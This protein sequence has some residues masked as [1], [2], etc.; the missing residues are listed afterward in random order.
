METHSSVLA[1]GIP[2]MGEPGG[3]PSVGSHRVRHDWSDLVEVVVNT[4]SAHFRD[5]L[6][7]VCL[8]H[9]T[10][11]FMRAGI[12][13]HYVAGTSH[14][15]WHIA[16]LSN[17]LLKGWKKWVNSYWPSGHFGSSAKQRDPAGW[18]YPDGQ[19][20]LFLPV[21]PSCKDPPVSGDRYFVVS[22][23]SN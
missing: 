9:D 16:S 23:G 5:Y 18:L 21:P 3:L 17:Y 8:F 4:L 13:N 20:M 11:S 1:W 19:P 12:F 6:C 15:A 22:A 10:V 14:W 7:K 2:G